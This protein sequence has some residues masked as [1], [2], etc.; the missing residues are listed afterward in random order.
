M[1]PRPSLLRV[2]GAAAAAAEAEVEEAEANVEERKGNHR[3]A[4]EVVRR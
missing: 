3:S 4:R 2:E 1:R